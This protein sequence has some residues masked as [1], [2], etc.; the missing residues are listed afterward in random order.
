MVYRG[1]RFDLIYTG[2]FYD[3]ASG[4]HL[5]SLGVLWGRK[6][7][8]T[9]HAV[10]VVEEGGRKVGKGVVWGSNGA[11]SRNSILRIKNSEMRLG[12]ILL[13]RMKGMFNIPKLVEPTP[14][15]WHWHAEV[16]PKLLVSLHCY[17]VVCEIS[18]SSTPLRAVLS[19][20]LSSWSCLV[21]D[22]I[23]AC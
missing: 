3:V 13:M 16:R 5:A 19:L 6:Q 9:R 1:R 20:V 4:G 11:P 10:F 14:S 21:A 8:L 23:S 2:V 12:F 22:G 15:R 18:H 17:R 7:P